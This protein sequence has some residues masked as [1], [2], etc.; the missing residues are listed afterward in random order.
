MRT[1]TIDVR[2]R[3]SLSLRRMRR[4]QRVTSSRSIDRVVQHCI[5][6]GFSLNAQR[7]IHIRFLS[8]CIIDL[9]YYIDNVT[10]SDVSFPLPV[11]ADMT[12]G[13]AFTV[14]SLSIDCQWTNAQASPA[15]MYDGAA[16]EED[17]DFAPS[18]PGSPPIVPTFLL[19]P[20]RVIITQPTPETEFSPAHQGI[21]QHLYST[22]SSSSSSSSFYCPIR[23][24]FHLF[25]RIEITESNGIFFV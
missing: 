24:H 11:I 19:P 12:V 17:D 22:S 16:E 9:L 23:Y 14:H 7:L 6:G 18:P 15:V 21:A 4:L 10:L 1:R 25:N 8:A 5:Y 3:S 2:M 13:H 20:E